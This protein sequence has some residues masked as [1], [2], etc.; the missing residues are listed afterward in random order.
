MQSMPASMMSSRWPIMH[1]S[2]EFMMYV[3]FSSSKT[4]K[5]SPGR[6]SSIRAY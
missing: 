5:Y 2:R 1:I 6:F 4:G 3:P